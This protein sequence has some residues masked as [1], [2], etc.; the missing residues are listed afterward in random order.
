M[1]FLSRSQQSTN[2]I[3]FCK[4][5]VSVFASPTR[6]IGR[7]IKNAASKNISL[8]VHDCCTIFAMAIH[9]DNATKVGETTPLISREASEPKKYGRTIVYKALLCGFMVSLSFGVTQVP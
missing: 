5:I 9:H 7:D 1:I 8:F 6:H 4:G 3:P 2:S